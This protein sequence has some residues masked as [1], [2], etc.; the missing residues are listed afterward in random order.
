MPSIKSTI[1]DRA[2][3]LVALNALILDTETTGLDD[4]AEIVEIAIV[5]AR[6]TFEFSSLVK[7]VGPI[8]EAASSVHG[9]FAE[10]LIHAPTWAEVDNIVFHICS[11][12]QVLAYN[13]E[14]DARLIR[15]SA[16]L[17]QL[18]SPPYKWG[19]LMK[20][21]QEFCGLVRW[22]KL[23]VAVEEIGY[24]F[25]GNAHRAMADAKAARA[26]LHYLAGYTEP[27][28]PALLDAPAGSGEDYLKGEV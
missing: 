7:P 28:Q 6:G 15:Q 2:R 11:P 8:P 10:H 21:Y 24:Q 16:A 26:V 25:E 14:Y 13:A 19:C 9:I 27:Q 23:S 5:D 20:A 22:P 3:E 17:H 12:R 1:A 4:S 18:N